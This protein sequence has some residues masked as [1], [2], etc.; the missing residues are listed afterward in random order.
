MTS[1]KGVSCIIPAYNEEKHI[2]N[3][4]GVCLKCAFI[5]EIIV[6][7][8]G[9]EDNTLS[10]LRQFGP[11]IQI[12]SFPQNRGKSYAMVAGI[13]AAQGDII[14]FCDGDLLEIRESHL[15]GIV[16]PLKN[17]LA[18]QVLA[19]RETDLAPFKKLTGERGYFK[20]D[21]V[22]HT[23]RLENTK[24]G[25]ETFLNHIFENKRT[26]CYL[27]PM[28]AQILCADEYLKAGYQIL[29]ELARQK[30]P[31]QSKRLRRS[32]QALKKTYQQQMAIIRKLI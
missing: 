22:E 4:V 14:V 1:E 3:V 6:V 18:D 10:I 8:D 2:R 15:S 19:I 20:K 29:T 26:Y 5:D 9:S 32:L 23:T 24:F 27:E 21:L 28:A 11:A 17:N 13:E 12:I 31:H 30:E 25:A 7:D 16:G